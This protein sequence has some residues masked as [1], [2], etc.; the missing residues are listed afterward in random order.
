MNRRIDQLI[1]LQ[2]CALVALAAT[3]TP[4]AFAQPAPTQV[5]TALAPGGRCR[6]MSR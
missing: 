6:A 5:I 3:M 2:G 4:G 1:A